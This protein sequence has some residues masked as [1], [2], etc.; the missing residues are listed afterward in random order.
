ME[1]QHTSWQLLHL[2]VYRSGI[3]INLWLDDVYQAS[4]CGSNC[5][6][7]T[8]KARCGASMTWAVHHASIIYG[9]IQHDSFNII[10]K[11]V[12]FF[13]LLTLEEKRR[14]KA[15]PALE[16]TE[17]HLTLKC[18]SV[19]V[20]NTHSWPSYCRVIANACT[21]TSIGAAILFSCYPYIGTHYRSSLIRT[22]T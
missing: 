17:K 8:S 16:R 4:Q 10:L 21:C 1:R 9:S 7:C 2:C 3:G 13:L 12:H 6:L 20:H 5:A 14:K 19:K 11:F 22:L 15:R 18:D